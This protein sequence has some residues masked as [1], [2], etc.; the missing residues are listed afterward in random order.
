MS[1][2]RVAAAGV[3][4]FS[5]RTDGKIVVL[6]GRE[7]ETVGWRQGSNKWSG[8]SGRVERGEDVQDGA[9]REFVE[10]S[11]SVV[12]L[13]ASMSVPTRVSDVSQVIRD[14]GRR[15][16]LGVQRSGRDAN[17]EATAHVSFIHR[18]P[19]ADYPARFRSLRA[20]LIECDT[21]FRA[22]HRTKKEAERLPRLLFPGYR[23]SPALTVV[24]GSQK[25]GGVEIDIWDDVLGAVVKQ[26]LRLSEEAAREARDVYEAWAEVLSYLDRNRNNHVLSHPAVTVQRV[27]RHVVGAYVNKC[28]LEK[29][30]VRWWGLDELERAGRHRPLEFRRFFADALPELVTSVQAA[31]TATAVRKDDAGQTSS[32]EP[33]EEA[34]SSETESGTKWRFRPPSRSWDRAAAPRW[35]RR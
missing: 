18:V 10:E 21:R 7:K 8:F 23:L 12:P 28:Y 29:S 22:Y 5:E 11:L 31:A 33:P 35:G 32:T 15:V 9:A 20:L 16:E 30:E 19:H 4:C 25:Q 13:T 34:A 24:G 2:V 6:L 1:E 3:L 27:N 17:S 26:S 14:R